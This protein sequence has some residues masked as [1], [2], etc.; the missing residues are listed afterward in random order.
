M[1]RYDEHGTPTPEA[2]A[3]ELALRERYAGYQGADDDY[4]HAGREALERWWD[5]KFGIR[6]HWSV[7]CLP[8]NG[9]ESWP[10]TRPADSHIASPATFRA[11]YEELYR[12][13]CP[14]A[15]DAGAWCDLFRRAGLRFFSFTTKHHDGFSLYDTRTR[16]RRRRVHTGPRAGQIVDCDLAYS[17]AETPFGRDIVGELVAAGRARDLGISLYFSHIDWFD[18]D[19]RIDDWNYQR[20]PAYTPDSDPAGFARLAARHRAQ[21]LELCT[22]YGPI[23]QISLDMNFPDNGRRHGL[24]EQIVETVKQIR[25]LQPQVLLRDRGIQPYGDYCTPERTVPADP[26]DPSST[27]GLPWKVIFPGSDHF[28]YVWGDR[29]KPASWL[30]ENLVDIVAKGGLFQVG[31]GPGPSGAWDAEVVAVL[32]QVG[33]WLAVNG[34]GIYATRPYRVF[35]DGP[36]IRYTQS[37]DG[38]SV[39]AFVTDWQSSAASLRLRQVRAR[40][41]SAVRMLGLDHVFTWRAD[42]QGMVIDIPAWF[43]DPDQRPC[44]TVYAFEIEPEC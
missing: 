18:A 13:F 20:D 21:L 40:A 22:N 36:N 26:H 44:Q 30:I 43:A 9:P 23:D 5:R 4:L 33:D 19:F 15:F 31:Y 2:W 41:G 8:A 32:E 12:C 3:E 14:A 29:Y 39:W 24:R 6:I 1:T 27:H 7:Y 34:R 42:E 28:S 35:A 11:Q 17:V 25:R 16:V 38:A 37:K 10:L